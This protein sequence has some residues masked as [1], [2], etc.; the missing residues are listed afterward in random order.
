[1]VWL[2]AEFWVFKNEDQ[3]VEAAPKSALFFTKYGLRLA[4]LHQVILNACSAVIVAVQ[5]SAY[6][7]RRNVVTVPMTKYSTFPQ[8]KSKKPSPESTRT[9]LEG[10]IRP[11]FKD[12]VLL[13]V[14]N[15][16]FRHLFM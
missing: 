13:V 9:G 16:R 4:E 6:N 2:S 15:N 1:M 7:A 8:R 5:K 11:F 10:V 3:V 12:L 14:W